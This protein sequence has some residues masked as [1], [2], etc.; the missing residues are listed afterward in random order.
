[1]P[2][3]EMTMTTDE[4]EPDKAPV[5]NGTETLPRPTGKQVN[6]SS[7]SSEEF[8]PRTR[9]VALTFSV[10]DHFTLFTDPFIFL[11]ISIEFIIIV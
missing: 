5:V 4:K 3:A 7:L 8:H 2:A 1:M 9:T 10:V 11:S 6:K